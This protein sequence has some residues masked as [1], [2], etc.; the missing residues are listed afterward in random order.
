MTKS[1]RAIDAVTIRLTTDF[2]PRGQDA[3]GEA[4]EGKGG[5]PPFL[6]ESYPPFQTHQALIRETRACNT[7]GKCRG[8]HKTLKFTCS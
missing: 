3:E 5:K 6:I 7:K 4:W 1:R 2:R 8:K